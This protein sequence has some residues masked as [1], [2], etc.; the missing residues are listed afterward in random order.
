M[1]IKSSHTAKKI[2]L[3]SHAYVEPADH[4]CMVARGCTASGGPNPGT[5]IGDSELVDKKDHRDSGGS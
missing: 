5:A 1:K 3:R 2:F 4:T